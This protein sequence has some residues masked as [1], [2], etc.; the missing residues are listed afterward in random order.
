MATKMGFGNG[1]N[2]ANTIYIRKYR[3]IFSIP[4][5]SADGVHALPPARSARPSISFKELEAQH[6]TETVS[7]PGKPEWKP[8]NLV[9][10][11]IHTSSYTTHPL[12]D[13]I[14]RLYDPN[15]EK[16]KFAC[17]NSDGDAFIIPLALL[18]LYDGGGNIL[19]TWSFENVWPQ[20][21][22]FDELDMSSSDVVMCNITLKYA[23][24]YINNNTFRAND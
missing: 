3:W 8:I 19:E 20:S 7:F 4:S 10:Y 13:W 14:K 2:G 24:A 22:D 23:R 1:L 5:I 6:L 18:D 9:L 11:D 16:Y 15:L 21:I 12:F 17:E